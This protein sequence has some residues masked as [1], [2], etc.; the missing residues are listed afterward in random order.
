MRN[1]IAC[2]LIFI[3][4]VSSIEAQVGIGTNSPNS[5]AILDLHSTN[6]GLLPPRMTIYQRDA[7]VAPVNGLMIFNTTSGC[8]NYFFSGSWYEYCG[9]I[10]PTFTCGTS[11]VSFDYNGSTVTYGTV[12]SANNRCWLDRNLGAMQVATSSTDEAAYGDYYQWGRLDD[13][14]QVFTSLTTNILSNSDVPGHSNFIT[15]QVFPYDWRS[16]QNSNLW[17]GLNGTNIPCP[18]GFRPPTSTEWDSERITWITN[19]ALGAYESP[20]KLTVA[21]NRD[22][23]DGVLK[24]KDTDGYYWSSS[25]NNYGAWFLSI[26]SSEANISGDYRADG[27]SIRCIKD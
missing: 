24:K 27:Y 11:T 14:H 4:V 8:P 21:G 7:I 10:S 2:I 9:I 3:S 6:R 20:L 22:N 17:Q 23:Y 16:P 18:E 15:V 5:A 1:L 13:G 25:I 19:N 12:V 26:K